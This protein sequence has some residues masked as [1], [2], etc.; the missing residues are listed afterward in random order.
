MKVNINNHIAITANKE[1]AQIC[2]PLIELVGITHFDWLR[3]YKDGSRTR[4]STHPEWVK[5][6]F[7]QAYYQYARCEKHPNLYRSGFA[8][9]D[10]WEKNHNPYWKIYQDMST[11]FNRSHGI[12]I[13][14]VQEDYLDNYVLTTSTDNSA[15]NLL[16]LNNME[17]IQKFII[18]F[19][20]KASKLIA[21]AEQNRI[22]CISDPKHFLNVDNSGLE[23]TSKLKKFYEMIAVKKLTIGGQDISLSKRETQC[24]FSLLEG[25]TTKEIAKQLDLSPRTVE[26]YFKNIKVKTN[27]NSLKEVIK[28][29][30]KIVTK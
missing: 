9:W 23:V 25:N 5:H 4:L 1:M 17:P 8:I 7:N 6:Y 19:K 30:S 10:F 29:F 20:N 26:S 16:Y 28:K 24:V 11:N 12:S 15:I 18:Y 22:S 21:L 3:T 2:K 14:H 13:L 27:T